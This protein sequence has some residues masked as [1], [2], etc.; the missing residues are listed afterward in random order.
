[1][2]NA[3]FADKIYADEDCSIAKKLVDACRE[4]GIRLIVAESITG[5]MICSAIVDVPGASEVISALVKEY[6]DKAVVGAGTVLDPETARAAMLAG[7]QFIVA[8]SLNADTIKLCNRYCVPC[9]PGI[10]SATELQQALELGAGLVKLF[11]GDVFKPS[12]LKAFKGPF[13]QADIMPTGGV[14]ADN[15]QDWFKAGAV[16]VGAGSFLTAGAKKGDYEE[17]TRTARAL[18]QKVNEVRAK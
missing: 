12:G 6:G 8:P 2:I 15:V 7:A 10:G 18:V 4:K 13:P 5:G 14:S 3:A 11:P 16:A 9:V 17:V 1:M